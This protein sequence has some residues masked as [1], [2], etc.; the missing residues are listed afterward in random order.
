MYFVCEFM[1]LMSNQST[2]LLLLSVKTSELEKQLR[3]Y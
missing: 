1:K 2:S 3:P